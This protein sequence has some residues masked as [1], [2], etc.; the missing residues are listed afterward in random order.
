MKDFF[1][2]LFKALFQFIGELL[3]RR[4][5]ASLSNSGNIRVLRDQDGWIKLRRTSLTICLGLLC[6]PLAV[7]GMMLSFIF[8]TIADQLQYTILLT[9]SV[10]LSLATWLGVCT[11]LVVQ[12][13]FNKQGI[14]Y[15][16]LLRLLFIP[17]N[18][19][20]RIID[21]TMIGSYISTRR[22]ILMVSNFTPGFAQLVSQAKKH[23]VKV[24]ASLRQTAANE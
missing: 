8:A 21:N 14:E 13:R 7:G 19:V 2:I 20:E 18:D 15:R 9:I 11:F 23:R 24:D 1:E 5:S 10:T 6:I 22:G 3:D 16:G 12:T 17:W 4:I